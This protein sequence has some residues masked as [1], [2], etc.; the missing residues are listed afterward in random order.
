[1]EGIGANGSE[2]LGDGGKAEEACIE[3]IASRV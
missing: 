3:N 2:I 1:M